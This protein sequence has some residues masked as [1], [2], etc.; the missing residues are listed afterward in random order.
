K[1][2]ALRGK[3]SQS[4]IFELKGAADNAVDG[5]RNSN[6]Y[7]GSCTLTRDDFAPWWSLDLQQPHK[8]ST[9]VITNRGDCCAERMDKAAIHVGNS[10]ECKWREGVALTHR[11]H[12]SYLP[13]SVKH[14]I[15]LQEGSYH[16]LFDT[17][18][19]EATCMKLTQFH[20]ICFLQSP[21]EA[22]VALKGTA[23]QSSLFQSLGAAEKAIDGNKNNRYNSNGSCTHTKS[24]TDP[25]WRLDLQE[26]YRISRVVIVNRGDCCKERLLGA[27]IHIGDS[28]LNNGND[29]P[30]CGAV[31]ST[32]GG[33]TH[34][35]CCCGMEG[36][37]VTVVIT[38]ESKVL[39]LCEVE[40]FGVSAD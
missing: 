15:I 30:T 18:Y 39:S 7:A 29:D 3:V 36:R 23:F 40:V 38:G 28:P 14:F 21:S 35:F 1:N 8:I 10:P 17:V 24:S 37:Y 20:H 34:T 5:D 25:W 16:S 11:G 6:Y 13:I 9:I 27:E 12:V 2:V 19:V 4:S 31:T 22:N 33:T 26:T 32:S